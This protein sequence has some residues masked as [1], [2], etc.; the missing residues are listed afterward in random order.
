MFYIFASTALSARTYSSEMALDGWKK[1]PLPPSSPVRFTVVLEQTNL[2]LIKRAALSVST[3][4]HKEYG[5]FLSAKQVDA[6]TAPA[7][8]HVA[9]V[10]SWLNSA[11]IAYTRNREVL[12][13][14]ATVGV[15]S[16]L[17]DTSFATYTD[18][19]GRAIVRASTY[20][21]PS[22]VDKAVRSKASPDTAR[23]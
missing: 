2:D 6:L 19:D 9:T 7:P 11:G 23:M 5:N 10:T 8:A 3:P 22:T 4:G 14:N 12:H 21:L 18:A 15:A 17:L 16:A 1:H 13:V 20:S